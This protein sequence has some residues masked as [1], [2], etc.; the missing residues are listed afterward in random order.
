[1]CMCCVYT[2]IETRIN[3][4]FYFQR[5]FHIPPT[6]FNRNVEIFFSLNIF[7]QF[8]TRFPPLKNPRHPLFYW[9][10]QPF[11]HF[12]SPYYYYYN[13]IYI[14]DLARRTKNAKK[15]RFAEKGLSFQHVPCSSQRTAQRYGQT[16]FFP[17][18]LFV[19]EIIFQYL[20]NETVF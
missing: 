10:K 18:L 15:R 11:Q 20:I 12:N 13:N 4:T 5:I 1:M 14:I 9:G 17:P 16:L 2:H 8:S 7:P 6:H 3:S 19:A